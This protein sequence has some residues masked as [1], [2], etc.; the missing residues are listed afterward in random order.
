MKS[1]NYTRFA[2]VAISLLASSAVSQAVN[3]TWD[4]GASTTD[5]HT[6]INWNANVVPDSGNGFIMDGAGT[7]V[8]VLADAA[9]FASAANVRGGHQ[10]TISTDLTVGSNL[11]LGRGNDAN[12]SA[13]FQ[14]A[15]TV[16][17][18]GM[19]MSG[20]ATAGGDSAYTISGG[21][22][23]IGSADT[24][25]VG[26][27]GGTGTLGGGSDVATFSIVGNSATVSAT[28]NILAR[29]SS[30]FNFTLGATGIDAIDTTGSL[31]IS[32]GASLNIFGAAYTGGSGDITIFE[33]ATMT[34]AFDVADITVTGF[35]TEGVD[36]TLTQN[37]LGSGDVVLTIVPEPSTFALL[38]GLFALT[39]VMVRR[40]HS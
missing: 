4:Y 11:N 22:L 20:N 34:G 16:S 3:R 36:W 35:G 21:S 25:D 39:A 7:G 27:D 26:G 29:A 37:A 13:V 2:A 40:R 12:G 31:N 14:T 1:T 32:T 8:T 9:G 18:G 15:G 6:A 23:T 38:G 30:V 17:L 5:W 19:D 10:F 28:S 33:A 24:F